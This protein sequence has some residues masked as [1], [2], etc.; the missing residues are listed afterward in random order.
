MAI[1]I[2]QSAFSPALGNNKVLY[3]LNSTNNTQPN[4]KYIAD[5]YVN[6]SPN[7]VRLKKPAH[8]TN[9]Y[10]A[11]DIQ[12]VIQ[13]YFGLD[14]WV[15]GSSGVVT[16][17]NS[18]VEYDVR[19]GEEYGPSSGVVTYQNLNS[20]LNKYAINASLDEFVIDAGRNN[21]LFNYSEYSDTIIK[22][23]TKCNFLTDGNN[24]HL[25]ETDDFVLDFYQD[26]TLDTSTITINTYDSGGAIISSYS[27]TNAQYPSNT[28]VK[29]RCRVYCGPRNLNISSLLAGSQPIIGANVAKYNVYLSDAAYTYT[30]EPKTFILD[31]NCTKTGY[32]RVTFLNQWGGYDS[33]NCYGGYVE[34]YNY[35]RSEFKK[36]NYVWK[37]L[38]YNFSSTERAKTQFNNAIDYSIKVYTGWMTEDESQFVENMFRSKDVRTVDT[39]R[40]LCIPINLKTNTYTKKT[41]ARDGLFQYEFEF[42]PSFTSNVQK[43]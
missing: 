8:P 37:N 5:V 4:F 28:R 18:V 42:T 35:Q 34:N 6:N 36:S 12:G 31:R 24:F 25:Q 22:G 7:Y 38:G 26:N 19:W 16:C 33:F 3:A 40:N 29:K 17:P 14:V 39:S 41:H 43:W 23:G 15:P 10:A 9:G 27:F 30:S 1:T 11:F 2:N 21:K 32:I 20:S 13:D